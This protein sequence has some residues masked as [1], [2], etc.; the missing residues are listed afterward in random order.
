MGACNLKLC[1]PIAVRYSA[2]RRQFGPENGEEIPVIEYQLQVK[3]K[4]DI[5]CQ[6][7]DTDLKLY[8]NYFGI[9]I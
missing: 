4:Q 5:F 6:N 2:V 3:E 9:G 1:L 8:S 7:K